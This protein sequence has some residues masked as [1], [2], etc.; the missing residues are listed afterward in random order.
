M[1]SKCFLA[2][3]WCF[4]FEWVLG[5]GLGVIET[6]NIDFMIGFWSTCLRSKSGI[7]ILGGMIKSGLS[8]GL[9]NCVKLQ[10]ILRGNGIGTYMLCC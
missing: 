6:W 3:S 10:L 7:S 4:W 1:K 8:N 2:P 5:L 9:K